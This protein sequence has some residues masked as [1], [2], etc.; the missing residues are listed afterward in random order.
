LALS[1]AAQAAAPSKDTKSLG[2]YVDK[3]AKSVST[4]KLKPRLF[5]DLGDGK[6]EHWVEF[7]AQKALDAA[8]KDKPCVQEAWVYEDKG[9]VM[10]AAFTF[11]SVDGSWANNADYYFYLNGKIAKNHSE[12]RRQ[13]AADPKHRQDPTFLAEV[14][15]TLYYDRQGKLSSVE[16]PLVYRVTEHSK[17]LIEGAEF[18]ETF[19]PQYKS[20]KDLPMAKLLKT[21]GA[22]AKP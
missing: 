20:V 21:P 3:I 5:V 16:K 11:G 1:A 8:C 10:L 17:E 18:P 2:A 12:L 9:Q 22:P 15:R 14:I 19:W 6:G 13:G 4:G 7:K